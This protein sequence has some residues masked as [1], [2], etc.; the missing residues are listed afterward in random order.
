MQTEMERNHNQCNQVIN[1]SDRK[2]ITNENGESEIV[3]E[4][5]FRYIRPPGVLE[6]YHTI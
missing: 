5:H 4:S 1:E 3:S 2:V 6:E